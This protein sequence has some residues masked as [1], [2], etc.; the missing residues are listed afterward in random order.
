MFG[1]ALM[2]KRYR[3]NSAAVLLSPLKLLSSRHLTRYTLPLSSNAVRIENPRH[4]YS[5]HTSPKSA[6]QQVK[7]GRA[8]WTTPTSIRFI[9]SSEV[10][11][12]TEAEKENERKHTHERQGDFIENKINQ[13][14]TMKD[15]AGIPVVKPYDLIAPRGRMRPSHRGMSAATINY[16]PEWQPS[17]R[18]ERVET[19]ST[20]NC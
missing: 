1:I 19:F 10:I 3:D 12:L 2:I 13:V 17:L 5:S 14:R 11:E 16:I 15:I 9:L 20:R 6:H 7:R 8:K 18:P 4:G